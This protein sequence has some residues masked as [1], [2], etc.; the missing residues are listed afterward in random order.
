M[1][2]FKIEKS[3]CREHK[4][5][6]QVRADFYWDE[7]DPAYSLTEC[8]IYPEKGYTGK[9]DEMGT[10]VDIED[11]Q[12]WEDSLPTE[13]KH[14]PFH[15]HFVYFP[16]TVMDEEILF[17]FELALDWRVKNQPVKNVKPVWDMF[18]T[19]ASK[20]RID[21]VKAKDFSTV[22]EIYSVK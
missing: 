2:F 21:S 6:C 10:P 7:K 20:V 22:S 13:M 4:G 18:A 8:K 5:L 11:Y 12:K 15:S 17:C 3:G 19:Q 16:D 14:L 1:A 9:V